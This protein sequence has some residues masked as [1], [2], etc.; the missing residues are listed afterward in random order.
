M[1]YA[2]HIIYGNPELAPM[3][4]S[5]LGLDL[6]NYTNPHTDE[7][8]IKYLRLC[9]VQMKS[10]KEKGKRCLFHWQATQNPDNPYSWIE[11][12]IT[13]TLECKRVVEDLAEGKWYFR[14][15]KVYT[16]GMA[17]AWFPIITLLIKNNFD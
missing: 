13:P 3:V 9:T 11:Q 5:A 6:K 14:L 17:G 15:R 10:K 4:A 8:S 16:K 2:R 7:F 12:D 1:S